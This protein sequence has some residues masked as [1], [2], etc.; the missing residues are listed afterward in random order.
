[1]KHLVLL[2][3][4]FSLVL[5]NAVSASGQDEGRLNVGDTIPGFFLRDLNGESFFLN[6]HLGEG[7][8]VKC[9]GILISFCASWCKPCRKE[10]PE[11]E[12]IHKKYKDK[13]IMV[14][15]VNVGDSRE[16]AGAFAAEIGGSIPMLLDRYQKTHE[17]VGRPGLPHTLLIDN[18]G[19]VKFVNTGFAEKTADEIITKLEQE[20]VVLTGSGTGTSTPK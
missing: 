4:V 20:I 1:M 18:M 14:F 15:L 3:M 5:L 7:A 11:L 6:D 17:I 19:K 16:K 10:I 9:N 8:K 2:S 13:G 12:K